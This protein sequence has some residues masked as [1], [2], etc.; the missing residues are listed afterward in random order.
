[1]RSRSFT[2]LLASII[3]AAPL[4]SGTAAAQAPAAA[5]PCAV[6]LEVQNVVPHRGRVVIAAYTSSES[7]FRQPAGGATRDA[8]V[9]TTIKVALCDLA[10][11]EVA[12][13]VFQDLNGNGKLDRNAVGIPSEPWG[14]SGAGNPFG[15]P[16]WDA[17]KVPTRGRVVIAL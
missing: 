15:P 17:T 10:G 8:S 5:P 6:E 1:M 11:S 7:F 3:L 9:D 14:T 4:S 16:T 12:V 13:I 2:P